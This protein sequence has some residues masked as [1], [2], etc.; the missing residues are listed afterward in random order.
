MSRIHA[1]QIHV[2]VT[3]L[4]MSNGKDLVGALLGERRDIK[5]LF[6]FGAHDTVGLEEGRP[7]WSSPPPRPVLARKVREI[8]D[9][10]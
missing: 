10:P 8:L 1:G 5:V 3:D 6:L 9:G 2:L 4:T 7:S